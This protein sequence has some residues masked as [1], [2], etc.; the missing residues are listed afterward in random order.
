[1]TDT[2]TETFLDVATRDAGDEEK[3]FGHATI[4]GVL[5]RALL[6]REMKLGKG[7][8]KRSQ[9]WE[10]RHT[11]LWQFLE[12]LCTFQEADD[13]DQWAFLQGELTAE[14]PRK[15]ILMRENFLLAHDSTPAT[16]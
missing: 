6:N 9:Q 16:P 2:R 1:M 4:K 3:P 13:K 12:R 7:Y 11:T 14:G 5:D 8:G 15:A 10:N